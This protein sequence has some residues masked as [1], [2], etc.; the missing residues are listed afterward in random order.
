MYYGIHGTAGFIRK[1]RVQRLI[2]GYMIQPG[3]LGNTF[4]QEYTVK[5]ISRGYRIKMLSRRYRKRVED[6]LAYL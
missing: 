6:T 4:F 1:Y 2:M 3:L 5:C